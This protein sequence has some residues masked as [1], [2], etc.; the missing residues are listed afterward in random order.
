MKKNDV[1]LITVLLGAAVLLLLATFF[2]KKN[3]VN[4]E[5][6]ILIQGV[7]YGRY[8]LSEDCKV[9][10]PGLLGENTLTISDGM[11]FM[12]E[13]VCPDKICMEFGKIHYNT[14]MIV[15]R[16]GGIVIMIEN[17]E[18]SELDAVGR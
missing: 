10:I 6:V 3:T 15:C 12:S 1:K 11:A 17:G 8:P 5:A 4:G 14:E 18:A 7:E 2:L 9:Q 13:A 16:P